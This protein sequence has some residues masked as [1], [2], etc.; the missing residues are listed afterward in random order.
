M[1][2]F[3][4]RI[5]NLILLLSVTALAICLCCAFAACTKAQAES[6]ADDAPEA[7]AFTEGDLEAAPVENEAAAENYSRWL[8]D[9]YSADIL[10]QERWLTDLSAVLEL[11]T[12]L[13]AD[14]RSVF[15][16]ACQNGIID[17]AE[18]EPYSALTR[19]YVAATV[20]RALG[21]KAQKTDCAADLTKDDTDMSTLVY[22]GYFLPDDAGR[23]Y[24]DATVTDAEYSMLLDELRRYMQLRGKTVL[25]FG[26]SIMY[27]T[28][29]HGSGIAD[30]ITEK[31]GMKC[32]DCSVSGASFGVYGGHSHIP[33][34]I[35]SAAAKKVMPDLI[36][37]NGGTNDMSYVTHGEI[38]NG[39]DPKS[40]NERTYAGGFEYSL[41]LLQ[42]YWND[43][44]VI[45]I[46]AHDMATV[47][48]AVEQQYGETAMTI[49][50]KW[51]LPCVNIYD[52][53]D[54]CTEDAAIREAYTD[55]REKYGHCDGIH[56]TAYGYARFYL[57]LIAEEI[58]RQLNTES[59]TDKTASA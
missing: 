16:A 26:D 1:S 9:H 43:V 40:F 10:T 45:Y 12:P 15:E 7:A 29:N 19:R 31:Y 33:T 50:A 30:M 39:F 22:Y 41:S 56:P 58:T 59:N 36:L 53:T 44:P 38:A 34:Q 46:R 20:V 42:K 14:S 21:Y 37:L 35:K 52:N 11:P 25:A 49:T 2:F 51:R 17:N 27:G 8:S 13:S 32:V 57:P 5:K 24:P 18:A 55:Y 28:G 3:S 4:G 6:A 47:E 54:F 48:D 23:V